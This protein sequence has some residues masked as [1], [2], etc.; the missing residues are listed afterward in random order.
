MEYMDMATYGT[1]T[2]LRRRAVEA[3]TGLSRSTIYL[4]IQRGEFPPPIRLTRYAVGWKAAEIDA[5][6]AARPRTRDVEV[7]P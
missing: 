2:I 5:W 4:L 7:Q 1:H 6:L 3:H